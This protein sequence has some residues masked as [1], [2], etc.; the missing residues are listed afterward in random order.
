MKT[1]TAAYTKFL[2]VLFQGGSQSQADVDASK[3]HERHPG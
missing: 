2:T 3:A 1:I